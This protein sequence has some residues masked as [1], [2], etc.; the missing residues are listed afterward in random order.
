M[1]ILTLPDDPFLIIIEYVI[2]DVK[3]LTQTSNN[4]NCYIKSL[5]SSSKCKLM[6]KKYFEKYGKIKR[7]SENYLFTLMN[8]DP[9]LLKTPY[10]VKRTDVIKL[11]INNPKLN[12]LYNRKWS[13]KSYNHFT[14]KYITRK[15]HIIKNSIYEIFCQLLVI[16]NFRKIEKLYRPRADQERYDRSI[17]FYYIIDELL[18][19][20]EE[21]HKNVMEYHKLDTIN[22]IT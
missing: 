14:R 5:I 9:N 11:M 13:V 10:Q 12:D 2:S 6:L 15:D 21:L 20:N 16:K 8:L 17:G 18:N 22:E 1:S 3:L 19:K 7:G 4:L